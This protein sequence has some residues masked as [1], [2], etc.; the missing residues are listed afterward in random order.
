MVDAVSLAAT[1]AAGVSAAFAAVSAW[2]SARTLRDSKIEQ[3]SKHM[4]DQ[5]V[6]SLE[7]AYAAIENNDDPGGLPIRDRAAWLTAAR[8]LKRYEEINGHVVLDGHRVVL[9]ER[10]GHWRLRFYTG[11]LKK[12]AQHVI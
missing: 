9:E 7:R 4:L 8:L 2:I 1:V 6:L 11:R 10:V 5:A 12:Q 3:S